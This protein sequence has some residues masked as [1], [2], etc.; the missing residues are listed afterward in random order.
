MTKSFIILNGNM[1]PA[2]SRSVGSGT[3]SARHRD[4][5]HGIDGGIRRALSFL[6]LNI[7]NVGCTRRSAPQAHRAVLPG[8]FL[9]RRFWSGC[10]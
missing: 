2:D 10:A 5:I 6:F 4:T 9:P 1:T 8:V 3:E 7:V